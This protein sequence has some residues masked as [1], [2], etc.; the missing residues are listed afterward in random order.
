MSMSMT[1]WPVRARGGDDIGPVEYSDPGKRRPREFRSRHDDVA[2]IGAFREGPGERGEALLRGHQHAHVAVAQ[3][4]ADLLGLQ[5]RIE[6]NEHAARRRGS[7]T[8]DHGLETLVEIDADAFSPTETELAHAGRESV[9]AGRQRGVVR[10]LLARRNR[11]TMGCPE[12]GGGDQLVQQGGVDHEMRVNARSKT[13]AAARRRAAGPD[14]PYADPSAAA[15]VS[16]V[17]QGSGHVP[18]EAMP[19]EWRR[20]MR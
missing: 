4:V 19:P 5:Q 6:R 8:G 17:K 14:C 2:Q 13:C 3:D 11:R 12:R 9:D 10:R 16:N 15:N 1:R 7:E 18:G 20:V